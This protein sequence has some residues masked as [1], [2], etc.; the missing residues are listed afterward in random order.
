[1]FAIASAA[2]MLLFSCS[3]TGK[4]TSVVMLLPSEAGMRAIVYENWPVNTVYRGLLPQ[5]LFVRTI[6]GTTV[7]HLDIRNQKGVRCDAVS[8]IKS[9]M[10]LCEGA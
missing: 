10:F 3:N 5:H 6:T 7:L 8:H 4:M 2:V 9:R 1:M